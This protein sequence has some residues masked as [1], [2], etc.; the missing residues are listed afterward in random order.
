MRKDAPETALQQPPGV[1]DSAT[2]RGPNEGP[3]PGKRSL[4]P[5]ARVERLGTVVPSSPSQVLLKLDPPSG[6]WRRVADGAVINS[7][8][9]LL[10]LPAFRPTISLADKI[11]L[12]L[13]DGTSLGFQTAGSAGVPTLVIDYGR[14]VLRAENAAVQSRLRLQIGEQ[15]GIL[16]FTEPQSEVA[17]DARR[18]GDAGGDPETQPAP[19]SADLYVT[20]GRFVWREEPDK[21][22]VTLEAPIRYTISEHPGDGVEMKTVP[23][24]IRNTSSSALEQRAIPQVEKALEFRRPLNLSLH[25]LAEDRRKEIRTLAMRCLAVVGDYEPLVKALSDPDQR[26]VWTAEQHIEQ[27]R[28]SILTSPQAAAE[29][30]TTMERMYGEQQGS[31]MYE[32]LWKY[33]GEDLTPTEAHQLVQYLDHEVVAFRALSIWNLR[34]IT[35]TT[36]NYQLGDTVPHRQAAIQRW[37]AWEKNL[38]ACRHPARK[39]RARK[40]NLPLMLPGALSRLPL[41]RS[42]EPWVRMS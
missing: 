36:L 9:Q 16:T 1:I 39:S 27:L 6:S 32:L 30:R 11:R 23:R 10:S 5:P 22:S 38:K 19:L 13:I 2:P 7:T 8:D 14:M 21:K 17:I 34:N 26:F 29:V 31:N 25:E 33:H 28:A 40:P 15:A 20:S 42:Q 3:P 35:G 24:W 4:R 41:K 12:Q 37:K 18:L